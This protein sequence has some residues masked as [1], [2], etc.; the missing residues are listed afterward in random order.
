MTVIYDIKS[1]SMLKMEKNFI[2]VIEKEY[3]R[4]PHKHYTESELFSF[5][6]REMAELKKE[7]QAGSGSPIRIMNE[8]ADVS[9]CLD[10]FFELMLQKWTPPK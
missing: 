9:N 5:I 4:Q 2:A 8:I 1:L 6:N 3:P 7:W 10:F